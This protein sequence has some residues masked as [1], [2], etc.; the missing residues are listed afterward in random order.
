[1]SPRKHFAQS[2]EILSGSCVNWSQFLGLQSAVGTF[3]YTQWFACIRRRMGATFLA[4]SKR[5]KQR[6]FIQLLK[7]EFENLS[8]IHWR[9]LAVYC[10]GTVDTRTVRL[11]VIKWRDSDGNQELNKQPRPGRAVSATHDLNGQ[12]FEESIQEN[13]RKSNPRLTRRP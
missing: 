9:L 12:N 13:R 11:W 10:E 4:M 2:G 6:T 7:R 8:G 3:W 5:I 1:M